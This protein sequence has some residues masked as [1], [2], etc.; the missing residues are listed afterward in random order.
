MAAERFVAF[1]ADDVDFESLAWRFTCSATPTQ[2]TSPFC[3]HLLPIPHSNNLPPAIAT[4][5]S[6]DPVTLHQLPVTTSKDIK[7]TMFAFITLL[8]AALA[9]SIGN[10]AGEGTLSADLV[11]VT[12]GPSTTATPANATVPMNTTNHNAMADHDYFHCFGYNAVWKRGT[13]RKVMTEYASLR[14][15]RMPLQ[16]PIASHLMWR[17]LLLTPAS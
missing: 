9:M 4:P 2:T 10:V 17:W 6:Y 5:P 3:L 1:L 16:L 14:R 8:L 7:D 12:A 15:P 13:D 11:F